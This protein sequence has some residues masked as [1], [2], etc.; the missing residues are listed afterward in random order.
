MVAGIV[1]Q[2]GRLH[3]NSRTLQLSWPTP[4]GLRRTASM[5]ADTGRLAPYRFNAIGRQWE[6]KGPSPPVVQSIEPTPQKNC[7]STPDSTFFY[8]PGKMAGILKPSQDS[9]P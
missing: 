4:D 9:T 6:R 1:V 5:L 2:A 7:D 3:H 8:L